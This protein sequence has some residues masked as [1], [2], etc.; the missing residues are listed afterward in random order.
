[1]PVS[2]APVVG[3]GQ[4]LVDVLFKITTAWESWQST[5]PSLPG[6]HLVNGEEIGIRA[7][8]LSN[9]GYRNTNSEAI[10][11]SGTYSGHR[12]VEIGFRGTNDND[13]WRHSSILMNQI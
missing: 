12:T 5:V 3:N 4:S 9:G 10:V 13:D 6:W 1:M 11:A 2:N 7:S 8:Q